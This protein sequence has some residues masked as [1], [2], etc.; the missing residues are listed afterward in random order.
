MVQVSYYFRFGFPFC[1]ILFSGKILIPETI[2]TGR[3]T[4]ISKSPEVGENTEE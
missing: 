2:L 4:T 3:L 1:H